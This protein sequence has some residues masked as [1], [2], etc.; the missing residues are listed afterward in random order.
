MRGPSIHNN[1]LEYRPDIDGLRA[2]AVLSVVAFHFGI[3]HLTG[4]F[5]GV[6]VFFV[7][8]GYLIS[9]IIFSE[10]ASSRFSVIA[11][12]ERRI[13]R[14]F[15]ALFAL[16]LV[17][18]AFAAAFFLPAELVDFSKSVL[19]T[20]FSVSNFY[21]WAHSGYFEVHNPDPLLHTWSLAVEEQFYIL[22]PL[23]LVLV[24]RFF[25][26][27][28]RVSV[29]LLFA[30]SLLSSIVVVF[31]SPV[32][33]F[34]M[35]FTRAWELLLGTI[36]SLG[37]FPKLQSRS[38]RNLASLVGLGMIAY[39]DFSFNPGTLFPGMSALVPCVGAA[40]IVGAGES[41]LS[42]V[43]SLLAWRPMVFVGLISYSFYLWHWPVLLVDQM[44]LIDLNSEFDRHF[45]AVFSVGRFEH[46]VILLV[47]FGLAVLSWRFVERPFRKGR[48]R[49]AGSQLFAMA[50]AVV[51]VCVLFSSL[52]L[53]TRGLPGRFSPQTI[54]IASYLDRGAVLENAEK[55]MRLGTCFLD[56]NKV[57]DSYNLDPCLRLDPV[58]KNYLLLG[59]SHAAALWLALSQSL[60]EVNVMQA[61]V[62][63]CEPTL[64]HS[65]PGLCR[66]VMDYVFQTYLPSHTVQALI[67]EADW[68]SGSIVPLEE[69]LDWARVH[70][71]PVIVMGCVP[72]YDAPLA[73]LLAYS[74]AWHESDLA[75]KHLVPEAGIL[76]VRLRAVVEGKWHVPFVS[77]YD[78]LCQGGGCIEYADAARTIPLMGDG[79]HFNPS[80]ALFV[81]QRLVA[82]GELR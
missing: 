6:D 54:Q 28:L 14:I 50:G 70:Q 79:D 75:S 64:H 31:Y 5:V 4:G 73:R 71:V 47:S 43:Y 9:S 3:F 20:T 12:Y 27:R 13:R 66:K 35:P 24:R 45:G 80:G 82:N 48:M 19:A 72:S 15:P 60:P 58:R 67:L 61:N 21:F 25:M 18:C 68:N 65:G 62:G 78:S 30:A 10:V 76:E 49:L 41:G 53:F 56:Q 44:G 22:F 29:V 51:L 63:G 74:V 77:L 33:A 37:M 42:A 81:V 46:L 38:L 40:L 32:T 34:F 16:L 57:T 55:S 2:V 7:I 8:S 1:A 52:V 59:D 39:A 17:Y 36:L 23:F 26:R 69:T 11:F